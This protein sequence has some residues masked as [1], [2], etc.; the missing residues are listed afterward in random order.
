MG[1]VV[2]GPYRTLSGR[3]LPTALPA[4]C[5]LALYEAAGVGF[6]VM[7]G[8]FHVGSLPQGATIHPTRNFAT[9]GT[10]VTPNSFFTVRRPGHFCLALHVA[11]QVGLYLHRSHERRLAYSL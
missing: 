3:G 6:A 4:V 8:V 11:M 5:C 7:S 1:S 2:T 9:L 10:F